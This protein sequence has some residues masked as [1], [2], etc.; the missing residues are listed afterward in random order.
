MKKLVISSAITLCSLLTATNVNAQDNVKELDLWQDNTDASYVTYANSIRM[1]SNDYKVYTAR[2]TEF[3]SVVKG[4]KNFSLYCGGERTWLGTK[5]GASYPS[6]T[7]FKG[8]LHIYPYTKKSGCGFYGLLL[9][10]GGKTFN[11]E[12]VAGSLEKTNSELTNCTVT[13]HNGA[14]LAMWTGVRG[15]RIAELNTEEGS[16]ILGPAKKGS[17]N[18]SYYVLGLSGNDAL[19][20]GQI[21]PTGKD[22][23]TKV[24]I[25]KEGAGTYRITGNDNLITGAIRILEGKVMLNNDVETA[26]TKK[27]AGAIGALGSTNPGVYV[28]EGAA[29]GGTGHSASIIDL[30]GNMEPGDNGIGTLTMA[31]FVTGKNVDLRLR[32]SSKL[33]FE[34]NSAEEYD[35]VIV[36]GNLNHWNIGQDFAPSDKTPIIYIQ[37]SENN[38][39]KVGDRLTLISAK[40]K[41]AREDI[42][43]NFR[44]QYPKSLTWEVEEIEENGTYSLVAEVKSLDYSGQGEVDV[45]DDKGDDEGGDDDDDDDGFD[46]T[47]D[48]TPLRTYAEALGK[49]I[50]VAAPCWSYDINNYS[51]ANTKTI[52]KEFNMVVSENGM[53]FENTEQSKN[54]FNYS[55]G[56]KAVN[57]GKYYNCVIRGHVFAWHKQNGS[58][59]TDNDN[60]NSHNYSKQE[61]LSILKNHIFKVAE[62]YKGKVT[63][64][65]VVNECLSDDQ[66]A[67]RNNPD[68]YDLRHSV[69]YDGIGEAFI[70]SAFVWAHQADPSLKLYLTDYGVEFKGI[71]KTEALYNL[72]KRLLKNNIPLHGV[73]I[74]CHLDAGKVDAAALAKTVE[75]YKTLGLECIITE[76][77][78]GCD[79][80]ETGLEQ[81]AKDFAAITRVWLTHDNCPKFVIWGLKDSDSWRG[82]SPL[83]FR[84][85]LS[86]KPAYYSIHK[87]LRRASQAAGIDNPIVNY[88]S[89]QTGSDK[90]YNLQGQ[91]VATNYHGIIITNGKKISKMNK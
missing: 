54:S 24:G 60:K 74:Q 82:N 45:D 21:A 78:L 3:N 17:G 12:D 55:L 41:T 59:I 79:N 66:T 40:G 34:I 32:P 49:Y 6:W 27:M 8:E 11:P 5:N 28:F 39:L 43:W 88:P 84:E 65:D 16:I 48:P 81:Q 9:S 86:K 1:G 29:I 52:G 38:T 26:R 61:L 35:K 46:E 44:I 51:D 85:N 19:L 73:G 71:A 15:V 72:A 36:E 33:Y 62:H 7:D 75:S 63:E 57:L 68:A 10:H 30:Y 2:Y 47:T 23:A 50:G 20:A 80:T 64:W 87:A 91:R 31:D 67:I 4:D 53:K 42:K 69:W 90:V 83:L 37:P 13:L 56:D 70:D 18:G 14:T 25:I 22:A 58:W 77:D 76:C 89:K